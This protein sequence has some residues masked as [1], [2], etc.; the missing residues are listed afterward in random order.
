[1]NEKEGTPIGAGP[2]KGKAQG[3][4]EDSA[5]SARIGAEA[6]VSADAAVPGKEVDESDD[7]RYIEHW[8]INE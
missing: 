8:G 4:P 7:Q 5:G 1:M 2:A 3:S 6:R